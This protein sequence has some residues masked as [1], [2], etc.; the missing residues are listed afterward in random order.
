MIWRGALTLLKFRSKPDSRPKAGSP[1]LSGCQ[2][3]Q[4][5]VPGLEVNAR[6]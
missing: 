4:A 2:R 3:T 1:W 5:A 6:P